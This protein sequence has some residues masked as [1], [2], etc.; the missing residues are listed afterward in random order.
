MADQVQHK[1]SIIIPHYNNYSILDECL[2]SLKNIL[3]QN[4]EIIVVDNN[5]IDDSVLL[6]TENHKDIIIQKSK[7][8]LGYAGGCNLGANIATGEYLLFLNNDTIHH[9]DF[10]DKLVE[11]LDNNKQIACVQPKIKNYDNKEYFDY[12]GASGGFIDYLVFPFCR[13]RIFNTIEKDDNQYENMIDVFWTSG[14]AFITRKNI[15]SNLAGFDES[16]FA[17]MEEI[18]LSWKC[19]LA[20]YK[21]TINPESIIFHHGGKTLGY[22]SPYKTYLNHRNSMIL[23]LTNYNILTSLM[24]FPL[25]LVLEVISSINDLLKLKIFHFV[26]HY[27]ALIALLNILYLYRRRKLNKKIRVVSD[28]LLFEFNVIFRNSI[29]RKYYLNRIKTFKQL[30]IGG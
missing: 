18:D 28:S 20:G 4:I 25:R 19:Y 5:S 17:H 7:T 29:V 22:N 6:L 16:L 27:M 26:A 12:A 30:N 2:K 23:L 9:E 14:T 13:G 10:L 8:N 21:C 3:Y 15:F 24:L 11:V 1:V